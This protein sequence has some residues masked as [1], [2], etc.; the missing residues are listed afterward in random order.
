LAPY[1]GIEFD[2]VSPP[3]SDFY[4]TLTQKFPNCTTRTKDTE[5]RKLT[6]YGQPNGQLQTI[7]IP[8]ADFGGLFDG[9]GPADLLHNKD[10]TFVN[11]TPD[12]GNT[13]FS[14]RRLLLRGDCPRNTTTTTTGNS[15][16]AASGTGS[17]GASPTATA[18]AGK[19]GAE[20]AM[21]SLLN[22][23][24]LA[25]VAAAFLGAIALF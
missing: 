4:V 7:Y 14:F 16:T 10:I 17:S 1:Q 15:T 19:S 2:I 11:M 23:G 6:E 20:K 21:G 12:D 24:T 8:W 22:A 25:S 13:V 3:G 5:Y 9:T 18:A